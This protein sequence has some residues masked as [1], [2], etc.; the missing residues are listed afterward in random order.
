LIT[1][2]TWE[3]EEDTVIWPVDPARMPEIL[4]PDFFLFYQDRH[5]VFPA[6]SS[7]WV[8]FLTWALAATHAWLLLFCPAILCVLRYEL[9]PLQIHRSTA[10]GAMSPCGMSS[11]PSHC[12]M[13]LSPHL[14][15]GL[16][17]P[18]RNHPSNSCNMTSHDCLP[19]ATLMIIFCLILLFWAKCVCVYIYAYICIYVYVCVCVYV[20]MC[21]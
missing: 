18:Q 12:P 10:V 5:T 7:D 14:S 3:S 1:R 11:S 8:R 4:S 21:I 17:P 15:S 20:Y 6:R 19:P 16:S 9:P 13:L 2:C